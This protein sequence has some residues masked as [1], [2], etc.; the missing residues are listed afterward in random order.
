MI[1]VEFTRTMARYNK[2]Q[3]ESLYGC[4]DTLSDA[5]RRQ[6]RGAF[7]GSI[8]ET[9]SHLLWGDQIWMHRFAGTP[10]PQAGSIA[11]STLMIEGW[12]Q[13]KEERHAFDQVISDWAEGMRQSDLEG[14]LNWFSGALQ[15]DVVK[16]KAML[17]LH[18]F[19][20]QTHH[21]GQ[22]HAMITSAGGQPDDTDLF[23]MAR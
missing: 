6:D 16:P 20:H 10:K 19:N 5:A 23:A 13:L 2:W 3:N 15:T 11:Q 14:D 9:L 12:T 17:V 1:T 21:R 8:H 4:A 22:V 18:M 7:F